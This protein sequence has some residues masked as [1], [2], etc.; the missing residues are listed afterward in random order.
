[1]CKIGLVEVKEARILTQEELQETIAGIFFTQL[2][3]QTDYIIRKQT[4]DCVK[5]ME[6]KT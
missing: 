1:M 2:G 4:Y 5:N 3:R 6:T